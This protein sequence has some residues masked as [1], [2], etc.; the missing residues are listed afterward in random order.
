MVQGNPQHNGKQTGTTAIPF[1][2][3][4]WAPLSDPY[5]YLPDPLAYSPCKA[6]HIVNLFKIKVITY[7]CPPS[8]TTFFLLREHFV[9]WGIVY[10]GACYVFGRRLFFLHIIRLGALLMLESVGHFLMS[11]LSFV[12]SKTCIQRTVWRLQ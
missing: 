9:P 8:T 1:L 12:G 7:L 5:M 2:V 3:F 4:V 6:Q 11:H 10:R